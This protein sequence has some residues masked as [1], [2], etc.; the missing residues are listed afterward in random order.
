MNALRPFFML[1]GRASVI[2]L[3]I[4]ALFIFSIIV[5]GLTEE[6]A[7]FKP[8]VDVVFAVV[9]LFSASAGWL[10][11]AV[12]Q[13]FQ[14]TTIAMFL[15]NVRFRLALGFLCGGLLV[16]AAIV[17]FLALMN[18]SP[19][20]PVVLFAIGVC[21]YCLTGLLINPLSGWI[22]ALMVVLVLNALYNSAALQSWSHQHA[23]LTVVTAV[24]VSI[25]C[26]SQLF[27][28][29]AFRTRP[30]RDTFA[31][32][33]RFSFEKSH[34]RHVNVRRNG[35]S[36]TSFWKT[37]YLGDDT[38]RWVRTAIFETYGLNPFKT[39]IRDIAKAWPLVLVILLGPW[40]DKGNMPFGE[41]LARSLYDALFRSPYVPQFGE[42]DARPLVML[43]IATIG[44]LTALFKPVMLNDSIVYP[45]SRLQHAAIQFRGGLIDAAL[46]LFIMAPFL[47]MLGYLLGW[48]VGIEIRL[49]FMPFFFR[50]LLLI[51][52]LMPLA[53]WGRLQLQEATW[54]K[55][56][57]NM[58]AVVI[59]MVCF[60]ILVSIMTAISGAMFESPALELGVLTIAVL[61]SRLMYWRSLV[62]FYSSAD[63]T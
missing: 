42:H 62:N 61:V 37:G 27:S 34:Q 57:N 9:F 38:W 24:T 33:G 3:G 49:D 53:Y 12:I 20:S 26:I 54:R 1:I 55:A 30:F 6:D 7:F 56:E 44:A 10:S 28:R 46:F 15:P 22:T 11:G 13:E 14:H 51:V 25:F 39:M 43:G 17:W 8:Y 29:S 47:L 2:W 35:R 59:G 5:V 19:Q 31:L 4:F 58:V 18:F 32:P 40:I 41:A 36:E 45:L 16:V 48:S 21:A 60:V 52:A 63:L 23:W 50:V